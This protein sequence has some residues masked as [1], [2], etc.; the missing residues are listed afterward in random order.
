MVP[1]LPFA[2]FNAPVENELE[3]LIINITIPPTVKCSEQLPVMVFIHGG[4]FVSGGSNLPVYDCVNLVSY[5][6][7][8]DSPIIGITINY[9]VGLGGFL[10][11]K[12]IKD[13]LAKDGFSGVGNF[14]LTDQQTALQWIHKYISL[15]PFNGDKNNVTI[16]GESAGG[17]SVAH[18]LAAANPAPFQ[19]AISMSG[20]LN[21]IPTWSLEQHEKRYRALLTHLRIDYDAADTLEQLR[22][23]PES[24]IAAATIPIEGV[25]V[26]TGNPCDDG[27]FHKECPSADRIESPPAWLESFMIGDVFDE[28]VIFSWAITEDTYDTIRECL[29]RFLTE[30]QTDKVL[31][32]YGFSK[33]ESTAEF[34]GLFES[35]TGDVI[36]KIQNYITAQRSTIPK[37]YAYHFDQV[38]SRD[39]MFRGK[40]YHAIDLLY[41]FLNLEEEM[42]PGELKVAHRFASNFINFAYGKD[43]WERYSKNH[44]WMVFGP[45]NG[46]ALKSEEDDEHR[47][48]YQRMKMIL[49]MGIFK[50]LVAALDAFST[51]RWLLDEIAQK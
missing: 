30:E 15:D 43:P 40:S 13:D 17:M 23:V 41:I 16:F 48:H 18:Q 38:G 32:L 14:G 24:V 7:A 42:S 22:Q 39:D 47:R 10:A 21:T 28:A 9:R 27:V 44:K 8:R 49:D 31:C 5:S 4:S 34:K 33:D 12:A 35:I 6:L 2:H 11:S 20:T 46:W 50:A 29:L 37:T 19:R 36:F 25:L 26:C 51:K 1:V 3:C 45:E